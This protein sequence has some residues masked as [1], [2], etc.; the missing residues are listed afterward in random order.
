MLTVL[1]LSY[2]LIGGIFAA[3]HNISAPMQIRP[4]ELVIVIA[5]WPFVILFLIIA[6]LRYPR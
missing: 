5:F 1:L 2:L 4:T 6:V 3:L